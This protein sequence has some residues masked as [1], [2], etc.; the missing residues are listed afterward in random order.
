MS[1]RRVTSPLAPE[2]APGMWSN[3]LVAGN[4]AYISGMT[5]RSETIEKAIRPL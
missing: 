5:A 3:C 4:V 1:F 2:P